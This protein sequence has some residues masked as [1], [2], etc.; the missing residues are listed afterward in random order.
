MFGKPINVQEML[1]VLDM[2]GELDDWHEEVECPKDIWLTP[3][4]LPKQG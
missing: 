4:P 2:S 1:N 3:P